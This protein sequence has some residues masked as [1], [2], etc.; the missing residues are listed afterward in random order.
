MRVGGANA[1]REDE[2]HVLV[3][4]D[5]AGGEAAIGEALAEGGEGT[6]VFLPGEDIGFLAEGAVVSI[7][8]A[9]PSSNAGQ[10]RNGFAFAGM[11]KAQ[12]RSPPLR[13][14]FAKYT[15]EVV[16][17][18]RT[19][20]SI[21]VSAMSCRARSMRARRSAFVKGRAKPERTGRAAMAGGNG[22]A[23]WRVAGRGFTARRPWQPARRMRRE[24]LA[25]ITSVGWA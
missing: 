23:C 6:L 11:T 19:M 22:A 24:I 5:G 16:E 10:T 4:A 17:L 3:E 13:R 21:F 15:E 18:A 20:A 1:F 2:L 25:A 9:R 8:R 7:S 14:M 12:R